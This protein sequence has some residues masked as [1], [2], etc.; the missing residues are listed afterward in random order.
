MI[1]QLLNTLYVMQEQARVRLDHDTVVVDVED[2]KA[3]Q[4]PL[5][6]L[7]GLVTFGNVL[8]SPKV[9]E[10]FCEDGR[11]IVYMS[12]SGRFIGRVYGPT[13][14]NVLLRQAQY[15]AVDDQP[16]CLTLAKS[17]AAGKLQ[18][19]RSMLQRSAR[20]AK[21]KEARDHL[22]AAA[23][24][25][26]RSVVQLEG[27]ASVDEV[28]G[29]E[30]GA[31]RAVFAV[32]DRMFTRERDAFRVGGR[33]R[34]P[35][36]DRTNAVLSF[37]YALLASDCGAALESVGLD[38]QAGFLHALRPGKP[39]LTLDLMEE[40]RPILADRLTVT[41]VNRGQLEED[42]FVIRDGG[43]VHLSDEARKR[44]I[45]AYQKRKSDEVQHPALNRQLPFGLVA[46]VQA[47][48]LARLLRGDL[49][50]YVPFR[51]H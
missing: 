51:L 15:R 28:R 49:H 34:R 2:E 12:Y 26:G 3:L 47:R 43:A 29:I 17:F 16:T 5:L 25:A 30:G 6:H 37:L 33:S 13:A 18:N 22:L 50:S 32:F 8:V 42:D 1:S 27:A 39:A 44:V 10:R 38:P 48:L 11:S 7:G 19:Q 40:L 36:L 4:V 9:I 35:P 20:D 14:G 24:N 21:T 46:H 31:A 41:L 45:V 23:E